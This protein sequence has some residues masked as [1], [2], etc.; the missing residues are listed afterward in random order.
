MEIRLLNAWV[1]AALGLLAGP[2]ARVDVALAQSR[3]S[4]AHE[5]DIVTEFG[6]VVPTWGGSELVGIDFDSSKTPMLYA[7]DREGRREEIWLDLPGADTIDVQFATGGPDGSVAAVGYAQ[8]SD[9][10]AGHFL[11]WISADRKRRTVVQLEP[12]VADRVALAGD[13][14]IWVVGGL[15][16]EAPARDE[17]KHNILRRYDTSGRALT[18]FHVRARARPAIAPDAASMSYLMASRDRVGWFT[19]G[20]EY[21]E[22]S[23][24]GKELARLNGPPDVDFKQIA[25]VG[26]D[27]EDSLFVGRKGDETFDFEVLEFDRNSGAWRKAAVTGPNTPHGARIL[28]FD[29]TT[30]VTMEQAGTIRRFTR[31]KGEAVAQ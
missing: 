20:C 11:I 19:N 9:S 6:R 22:F 5:R 15:R 12:Y 23:F 13:G 31:A 16:N 1:L 25:G 3:A 28:G 14:S 17:S 2:C 26:L 18:S 7:V 29:G 8:S 4:F 27:A 24:D 10:H 30:L 21:I